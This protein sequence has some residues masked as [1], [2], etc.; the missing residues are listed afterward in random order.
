V[1][2]SDLAWCALSPIYCVFSKG[3]RDSAAETGGAVASDIANAPGTAALT[4]ALKNHGPVSPVT[5]IATGAICA[6]GYLA[7]LHLAK[8]ST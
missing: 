6:A 4:L 5:L 3:T 7:V 2:A 8:D 1:S